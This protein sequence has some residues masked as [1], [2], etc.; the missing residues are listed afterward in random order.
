MARTFPSDFD[1]VDRRMARDIVPDDVF[2]TDM[3]VAVRWM[4]ADGNDLWRVYNATGDGNV[5]SKVGLLEL[6]KARIIQN[7]GRHLFDIEA[8]DDE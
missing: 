6:A 3:I 7:A 1:K 4:D 2:V 5:S 8:A